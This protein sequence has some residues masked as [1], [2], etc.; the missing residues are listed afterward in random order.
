[1]A[2]YLWTIAVLPYVYRNILHVHI[3][4]VWLSIECRRQG[5]GSEVKEK[6]NEGNTA[7]HN[8]I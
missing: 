5:L 1:M 6:K 8:D 4:K 3:P 7:G 2:S